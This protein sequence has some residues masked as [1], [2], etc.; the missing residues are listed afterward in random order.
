MEEPLQAARAL[1][2]LQ[3][4]SF[5][6]ED[7]GDGDGGKGGA[8]GTSQHDVG[9]GQGDRAHGVGEEHRRGGDDGQAKG[10]SVDK[11]QKLK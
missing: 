7:R 6:E 9:P 11:A 8:A 1:T 3:K 10:K 5:G 4:Q 2:F